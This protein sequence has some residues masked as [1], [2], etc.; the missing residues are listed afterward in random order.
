MQ[1]IPLREILEAQAK[2]QQEKADK[3]KLRAKAMKERGLTYQPEIDLRRYA[4]IIVHHY[5]LH[6]GSRITGFKIFSEPFLHLTTT[7]DSGGLFHSIRHNQFHQNSPE[8]E[9]PGLFFLAAFLAFFFAANFLAAS[10][11][12]AIVFCTSFLFSSAFVAFEA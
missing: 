8:S 10:S 9:T 4:L 12:F 2:Q 7:T 5:Y 1:E 11:S 6:A 3:D